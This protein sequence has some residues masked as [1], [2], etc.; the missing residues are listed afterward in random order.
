MAPH[1][2]SSEAPAEEVVKC[3]LHPD[4]ASTGRCN[5][6]GN[7]FCEDCV[8]TDSPGLCAKCSA[9]ELQRARAVV[10]S[11]QIYRDASLVHLAMFLFLALRPFIGIVLEYR[12]VFT[13]VDALPFAGLG[14]LLFGLRRPLML[15][16]SLGVDLLLLAD[17]YAV[18]DWSRVFMALA[19]ALLT[20]MLWLRLPD[21]DALPQA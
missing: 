20:T 9:E 4:H 14:V 6:C 5:R 8:S 18:D 11:P 15:L 1:L 21:P 2:K 3:A 17:A 10:L 7:A 19:A 16:A 12:H 13:V